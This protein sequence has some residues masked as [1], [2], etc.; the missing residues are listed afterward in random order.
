MSCRRFALLAAAGILFW[1][2]RHA[3][4]VGFFNDDAFY[5]IGAKSLLLGRYAELSAPGAPPLVNYMP[6]WPLLLAPAVAL[7]GD[8]LAILQ[9]FAILIHLAA[10]ALFAAVVEDEDGAE[11]G[12]WVLACAALSPLIA[13]TAGTLLSD[14][15]LLFLAS[16]AL[17]LFSRFRR[18]GA[19]SFGLGAVL[20]LAALARPTGICLALAFAAVLAFDRRRRP[21]A[22]ALF[23]A[24]AALG[25]WL[26]RGSLLA[27]GS[28]NYS[29]ELF[30]SASAAGFPVVENAFFALRAVFE[31]SLWRWPFGNDAPWAAV[32]ASTGAALALVGSR[33]LRRPVSRAAA[34]FGVLFLLPHWIWS[35]QAE[36]YFVPLLP[37][38]AWLV[39][40]GAFAAAGAGRRGRWALRGAA[41]L[42]LLFSASPTARVLAA[43]RHPA[44][45][46]NVP[47][48]AAA[49]WLRARASGA[50]LAAEYDGRW[51]LLTGL[52]VAHI[53]YDVRDPASLE[54]FCRRSGVSYILVEDTS[55]GLRPSGGAYAVPSAS[56]LRALL[57]AIPRASLAFEDPAG[58]V[59][60]WRLAPGG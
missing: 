7:A 40:R 20:A 11:I 19:I 49:Q 18:Q 37:L 48:A 33:G 4:Y 32:L 17:F 60:V 38:A 2:C 50:A 12:D 58:R 42:S 55:F 59:Q 28:W 43:S 31:R 22:L 57:R 29:R 15:P 25:A 45:P 53:P 51:H 39:L 1:L 14:G 21:A 16:L 3:Y 44:T 23:P 26:L 54:R 34:L 41:V 35:K 30:S 24:A 10:L 52:S 46:L 27:G 36:R 13:S 6:G 5:L 8:R 9:G 56:D 47:P